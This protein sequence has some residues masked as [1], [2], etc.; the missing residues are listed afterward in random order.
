[1]L[2]A[3]GNEGYRFVR[4]TKGGAEVSTANPY[5]FECTGEAELVAVF[6][7]VEDATGL[8]GIHREGLSVYP[9]PTT[10]ELWLTVPEPVE[11]TIEGTIESTAAAEVLVYNASGQLVLRVPTYGASASSAPAVAGSAPAAM[12]RIRIDLSGHPAGVYI[13]RVG[14]AVAKVV[15]M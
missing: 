6:E 7:K 5:T 3:T 15:R 13:I 8:L 2:T 10:G 1:R 11:G 4:W 9:N 14:H 12:G